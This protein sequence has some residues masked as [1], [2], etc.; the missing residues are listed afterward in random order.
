MQRLYRHEGQDRTIREISEL[1]GVKKKTLEKRLRLNDYDLSRCLVRPDNVNLNDITGKVF[2]RWSVLRRADNTESGRAAWLCKCECGNERMITT[3]TLT[4][5]RSKSCGCL[6]AEL[7]TTHGLNNSRV[8][9]IWEGMQQRCYN[10]VAPNHPNYGGRG[11][12]IEWECIEDFYSDMGHPPNGTSLD[13]V[14]N[15]GNYSKENCRWATQS[16]QTRNSRQSKR[17][18][19][20]GKVY[21]TALEAGNA[22]GVSKSVI[23]SRCNGYT[24]RG[25]HYPPKEHCY[26]EFYYA[27]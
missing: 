6:S 10:E 3:S 8:Q 17:W 26:S 25:K 9:T 7:T 23:R 13:R 18:F 22:L 5:G 20:Y 15:D 1:I 11:I 2:S 27:R 16:Q 12:K 19:L 24:D 4:N 14:D 21:E